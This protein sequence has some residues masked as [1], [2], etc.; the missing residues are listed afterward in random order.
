MIQFKQTFGEQ[1][2]TDIVNCSECNAA[3]HR[4]KDKYEVVVDGHTWETLV[5]GACMR[6]E[7]LDAYSHACDKNS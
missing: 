2:M 1:Q 5:C 7:D 6:D 3:I 4:D